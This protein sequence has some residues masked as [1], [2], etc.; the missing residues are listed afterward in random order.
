MNDELI[1]KLD[2]FVLCLDNSSLFK[3]LAKHKK[4]LLSDKV[5]CDNIAKLKKMDNIHSS[6]YL[7]LKTE[8]INNPHYIDYK[9]SEDNVYFLVLDINKKLNNLLDKRSCR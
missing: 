6:E 1:K 8:I 9:K 5:L 3:G 7:T 2:E 4:Q